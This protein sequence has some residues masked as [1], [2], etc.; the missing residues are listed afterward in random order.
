MYR[1]LDDAKYY[2]GM[3]SLIEGC[4][5][6]ADRM[7]EEWAR[8]RGIIQREKDHFPAEWNKYNLAAGGIRNSQMLKEGKPDMVLAFH[9]TLNQ[10][11]G[12]AD[13]VRKARAA[14]IPTFV[15]PGK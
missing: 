7:A 13:M 9:R 4:A 2:Y 6:G 14:G 3:E 12:T 8:S 10:S 15:F 11:K 1:T 5:R